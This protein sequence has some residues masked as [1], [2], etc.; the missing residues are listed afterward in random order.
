MTP[1]HMEHLKQSAKKPKSAEHRKKLSESRLKNGSGA[2][3]KNGMFGK[4]YKL[5][6]Y[7]SKIAKKVKC[8]AII[9]HN[10]SD[11]AAFVGNDIKI[12]DAYLSLIKRNIT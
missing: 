3:E 10:K 8:D 11:F 9:T 1:E 12:I 4:G 2:G 6:G 7:N 5:S